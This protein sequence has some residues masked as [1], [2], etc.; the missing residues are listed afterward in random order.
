MLM[1]RTHLGELPV[2][3]IPTDSLSELEEGFEDAFEKTVS[4]N[5][6]ITVLKIMRNLKKRYGCSLNRNRFDKI[7][8]FFILVGEHF[9]KTMS[10]RLNTRCLWGQL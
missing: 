8:S 2:E 4:R 7:L 3:E 6:S 10:G 1:L 9:T 5:S